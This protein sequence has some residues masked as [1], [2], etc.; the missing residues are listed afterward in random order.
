MSS[1]IDVRSTEEIR[2]LGIEALAEALGP[3][4]A[5]RFLQS[6]DLWRGDY[7]K[8][9]DQ[10]LSL[11]L[12]EI[13]LGIEK[14]R[15]REAAKDAWMDGRRKEDPPRLHNLPVLQFHRGT[16]VG[17]ISWHPAGLAP[18]GACA[19]ARGRAGMRWRMICATVTTKEREDMVCAA[20]VHAAGIGSQ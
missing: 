20:M 3:V 12:N 14:R 6:F 2:K 9:R 13:V 5:V 7:T 15:R 17:F 4:D 19:G 8:E 18:A 10:V 1:K 11:E 16:S